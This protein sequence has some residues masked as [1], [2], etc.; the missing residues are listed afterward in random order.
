MSLPGQK[1]FTLLEMLVALTVFALVSAMVYGGQVAILKMK[2][3][4]EQQ[5]LLLKQLQ[6][7]MVMLER[8]IS[9]HVARPVRDEFGD[10]SPAMAS[11]DYGDYRL[12]LTRAGWLNP[13]GQPRSTLQRVAYGVVDEKLLRYSWLTLDRAQ[14]SEPDRVAVLEGVRSLKLRFLDGGGEWHEQWPPLVAGVGDESAPQVVIPAAVELTL[15]LVEHG[16]F[17]RLIPLAGGV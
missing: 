1:G 5:A 16:S 14:G 4:A 9:Q 12:S 15:E 11:A 3:G 10:T 8:D 7:A 17:R 2:A 13:L 6:G